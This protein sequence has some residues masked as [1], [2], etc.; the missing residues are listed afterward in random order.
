[1]VRQAKSCE[2]LGIKLAIHIRSSFVPSLQF[3]ECTE[4]KEKIA[5]V[6]NKVSHQENSASDP[7][8]SMLQ[9][10]LNT[11]CLVI[12]AHAIKNSR[13]FICYRS[14]LN[15]VWNVMVDPVWITVSE[16]S[17]QAGFGFPSQNGFTFD[18]RRLLEKRYKFKIAYF[19]GNVSARSATFECGNQWRGE[20]KNLGSAKCLILG[21]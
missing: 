8:C 17:M 10:S 18:F 19:F 12:L 4:W 9:C 20:P 16:F 2:W 6:K 11:V 3:E 7:G 15:L 21:E 13:H 14:S 1:M 5:Q